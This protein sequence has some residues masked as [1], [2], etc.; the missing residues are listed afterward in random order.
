VIPIKLKWLIIVVLLAGA[1]AFLLVTQNAGATYSVFPKTICHHSPGQDTEHT[2]QNA[3][4]YQGHLG[5]PHNN[6]TFDT[7]GKCVTPT[8]TVSLTPTPYLCDGGDL[9]VVRQICPTAEPTP[10]ATPEATL[11]Q[12][13]TGQ[14]D[15]RSDG[16]SDGRHT[17]PDGLGC[18]A[19]ECK[20]VDE[21]GN[22]VYLPDDGINK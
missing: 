9:E 7:D 3:Q 14:G 1:F 18:A 12:Q 19:H 4:S 16:Q 11:T 17:P 6:E 13:P 15:G 22:P 10:T 5:T 8:E 2:F 21:Q 20:A